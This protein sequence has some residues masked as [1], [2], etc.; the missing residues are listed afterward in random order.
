MDIADQVE[1]V[2]EVMR[3]VDADIAE[4]AVAG[5][6]IDAWSVR[7]WTELHSKFAELSRLLDEQIKW[8]EAD[9]EGY[10]IPVDPADATQCQ[11][12]Q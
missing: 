12:C 4:R 1:E 10:S 2:R 9:R 8:T 6:K 5:E 7:R 11:S 3:A